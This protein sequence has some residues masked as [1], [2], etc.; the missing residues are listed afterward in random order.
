MFVLARDPCK[1]EI[2]K[3]YWGN[4]HNDNAEY[5]YYRVTCHLPD[6]SGCCQSMSSYFVEVISKNCFIL[7]GL[8]VALLLSILLN[9]IIRCCLSSNNSLD[10]HDKSSSYED[11]LEDS[12]IKSQIGD[13]ESET[14]STLS[15][16]VIMRLTVI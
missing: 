11:L 14:K 13:F 16:I 4:D 2:I 3:Y 9:I 10:E 5:S 1:F 6:S 8:F 7:L 15:A 12:N